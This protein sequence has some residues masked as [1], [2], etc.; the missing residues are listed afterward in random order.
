MARQLRT[1][2]LANLR[3][4]SLDRTRAKGPIPLAGSTHAHYRHVSGFDCLDRIC[5]GRQMSASYRALD[6]LVDVALDD[7]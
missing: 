3:R 6:Q 5:G 4:Y 1:N 2:C 7:R